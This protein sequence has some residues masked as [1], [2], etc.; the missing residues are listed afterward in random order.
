MSEIERGIYMDKAHYEGITES[1][2]KDLKDSTPKELENGDKVWVYLCW[3]VMNSVTLHA[4][5]GSESIAR[6]YSRIIRDNYERSKMNCKVRIDRVLVNHFFAS[7]MV[8]YT[9]ESPMMLK[10][11]QEWRDKIDKADKIA[12]SR[13]YHERE[14]LKKWGEKHGYINENDSKKEKKK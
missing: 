5:A 11:M 3:E 8:D 2:I 4:I 14:L 12:E 10:T 7:T 1:F 9:Y 13:F 6:I